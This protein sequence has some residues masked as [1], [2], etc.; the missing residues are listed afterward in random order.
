MTGFGSGPA[1]TWDYMLDIACDGHRE[2]EEIEQGNGTRPI[3]R[4][5]LAE[6]LSNSAN[7]LR[8]GGENLSLVD[9]VRFAE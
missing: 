1:I 9:V 8:V 4:R 3:S 5:E 6:L 7:Q 2:P